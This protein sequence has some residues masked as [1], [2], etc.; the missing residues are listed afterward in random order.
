MN[1]MDDVKGTLVTGVIGEDVFVNW[2][3]MMWDC[4][5]GQNV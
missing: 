4:K 5:D 3:V 1:D 2:I